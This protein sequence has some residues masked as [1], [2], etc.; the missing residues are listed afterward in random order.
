MTV[1]VKQAPPPLRFAACIVKMHGGTIQAA[2]R[3]E[4]GARFTVTIKSYAKEETVAQD[5]D[6][7]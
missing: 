7:R 4:G 1:T 2:N 6:R 3:V 5:T